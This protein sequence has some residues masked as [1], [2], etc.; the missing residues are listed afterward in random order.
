VKLG[1]PA[2]EVIKMAD[3]H[4]ADLM[5]TGAKGLGAIAR[6]FLGSVSTK[7]IQ[8]SSCSMLVVR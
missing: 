5:V 4:K 3:R 8:H 6:F 7:L 2:D 1:H